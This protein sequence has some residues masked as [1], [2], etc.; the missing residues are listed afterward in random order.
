MRDGFVSV[1][2][3]TP[4]V[5]VAD[6]TFNLA[7]CVAAVEAAVR[8]KNATVV[9]LPELALTGYSCGDLLLHDCLLDTA[10]EALLKLAEQTARLQTL[11][12]AGVPLRVGGKLYNC[13]A[14]LCGGSVLGIVPKQALPTYGEFY[15]A[16]HFS[17]G[18][19]KPFELAAG[20]LAGVPFGARQ[21]FA[22]VEQPAL[23]VA[24]EVCEDL[25]VPNPPSVEHALA[26]ATLICNSSAS[27]ESVGK[28]DYRRQLVAGQSARLLCGYVYAASGSG[29]STQDV[30]FGGHDLIAENGRVLAEVTPLADPAGTACIATEIDVCDLANERRRMSTFA[31][32]ASAAEAGYVTTSFSVGERAITLTRFVDPQPFV[33][34]DKDDRTRRCEEVFAIQ[35]RGLARRLRHTGSTCA[36]LGVSGGL[37]STLA[38]L[39]TARAFD[40]LGLDRHGIVAVTMPGFGTTT[41]THSNATDLSEA[42]GV[43][44]REISIV[45][46]VRRHFADI[47]HDESVHDTTYEN[48]QARER[49]QILMDLANQEGGLVVGT[50]DLSELA[51]GW[52][53]YNGDHMSM[54]G[55]NGGIPKTLVRHLVRYV[56]DTCGDDTT[57]RVLLDVLDTPV[58]PE[59]LPANADGTIAQQTEDLV[60]PYELHDFFLYHMVRHGFG[61]VKI[62]RLADY[63]LGEKYDHTT[64][65][66]W[67]RV[68][69]R[70]FFSQQFKRSCLPDGPKVGS[71]ALSPRG[72][73]RMPSDAM[74][75]CWLEELDQLS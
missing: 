30:V 31:G 46:S 60:G 13:A 20:R 44:L 6:V 40:E 68:F 65:L 11:V 32:A 36:V 34:S 18:S 5:R 48:S 3:I 63:A 75:T 41:R 62:M 28:A 38:L 29:E 71:V 26:G 74:A 1:A 9:V 61:P 10:E 49:T 37:D 45:D 57:Q 73:L 19:K 39:V 8:E 64:M 27:S 14:A 59:L 70:R 23:V 42:L 55:V 69:V 24:L 43:Q 4:E 67:L 53:T 56:A 17:A 21:L 47:G 50:G 16:R 66:T 25:W 33:P 15:E 7:A 12:V 35:V 54:Y 72:D 58:S 52:A 22:C 2:A 51:L